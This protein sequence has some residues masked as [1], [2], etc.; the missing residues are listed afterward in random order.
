MSGYDLTS[1]IIGNQVQ[2]FREVWK[3]IAGYPGDPYRVSTSGRVQRRRV[4]VGFGAWRVGDENDWQDMSLISGG[5]KRLFVN[6][7]NGKKKR[8]SLGGFLSKSSVDF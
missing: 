6:L 4:L 5:D 1:M 7:Y 3:V 8:N 2:G